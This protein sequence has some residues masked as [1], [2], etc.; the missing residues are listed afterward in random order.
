MEL[1]LQDA[2][3]HIE[4]RI[5]KVE[6]QVWANEQLTDSLLFILISWDQ[7]DGKGILRKLAQETIGSAIKALD[8]QTAPDAPTELFLGY[9]RDVFADVAKTLERDVTPPTPSKMK[10]PDLTIIPGGKIE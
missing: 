3:K 10:P 1:P 7:A 9:A 5:L 4:A 2:I 6:A 8:G